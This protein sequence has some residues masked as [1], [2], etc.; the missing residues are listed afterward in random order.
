MGYFAYRG[1]DAEGVLVQGVLEGA[2]S[3]AV[4]TQLF[5][6]GI[7]PIEIGETFAAEGFAVVLSGLR[8]GEPVVA[9]ATFF[10]DAGRRLAAETT[11]G[12]SP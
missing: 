6:T 11:A 10:V 7:T 8:A 4:A 2:D 9:R 1:R 5:G 12:P 3:S